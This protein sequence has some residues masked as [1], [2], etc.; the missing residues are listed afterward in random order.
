MCL[1]FFSEASPDLSGRKPLPSL[2]SR[3]GLTN[4]MSSLLQK[5][6][7]QNWWFG[8]L[9]VWWFGTPSPLGEGRGEVFVL[10]FVSFSCLFDY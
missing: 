7:N 4:R 2:P 8:C 5:F 3:E 6:N 9:V 10:L 1:L